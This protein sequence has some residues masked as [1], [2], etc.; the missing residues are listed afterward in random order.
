MTDY[1]EYNN[2]YGNGLF[3]DY[4]ESEDM[5]AVEEDDRDGW[6]YENAYGELSDRAEDMYENG[7]YEEDADMY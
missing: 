4:E 3:F 1:N 6:Y 5:S 7:F 2:L